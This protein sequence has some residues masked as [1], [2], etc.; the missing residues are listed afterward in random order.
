MIHIKSF[1]VRIS[2]KLNKFLFKEFFNGPVWQGPVRAARLGVSSLSFR[3][4]KIFG[5][6]VP[7]EVDGFHT[8]VRTNNWLLNFGLTE[9]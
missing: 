6:R 1:T 7:L 2:I 3:I 9:I 4:L 5:C 8:S